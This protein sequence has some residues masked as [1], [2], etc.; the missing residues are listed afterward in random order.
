MRSAFLPRV[1]GQNLK[2][3]SNDGREQPL[4][5]PW[6]V[7]VAGAVEV[8]SKTRYY[9][10]THSPNH[11]LAQKFDFLKVLWRVNSQNI[12][13]NLPIFPLPYTIHS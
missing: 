3:C 4:S 1:L 13:N 9:Y 10:V 7:Q 6:V 8:N 11:Y 12:K 5:T 2:A